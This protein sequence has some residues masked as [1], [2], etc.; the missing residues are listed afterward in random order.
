MGTIRRILL[1][2]DGSE[3][4][5]R[6]ARQAGLLAKQC[7]AALDVVYA[8][9]RIKE[10]RGIFHAHTDLRVS[11]A[12]GHNHRQQ[13]IFS[14]TAS[15]LPDG[16]MPEWHVKNDDIAEAILQTAV[17]CQSDMIIMGSRSLGILEGILSGSVIRK[18]FR[19]A[20]VP[21]LFVK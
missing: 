12:V 21:V 20:V 16:I 15:L 1:I 9:D 6:A 17:E 8:G 18:V 4:G 2:V 13:E 3:P 7:G 14:H 10:I 19:G 5:Y 11:Y